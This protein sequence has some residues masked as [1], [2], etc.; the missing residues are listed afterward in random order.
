MKSTQINVW[1][2]NQINDQSTE[3]S[4]KIF[5]YYHYIVYQSKYILSVF[6]MVKCSIS[7][8]T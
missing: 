5:E 8:P 7:Q 4:I 6:K 3:S 2:N 1:I